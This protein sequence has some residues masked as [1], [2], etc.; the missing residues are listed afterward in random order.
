MSSSTLVTIENQLTLYGYSIF[1]IL[2][3]IGN[4]FILIIFSRQ[5]QTAC[6]IYLISTAIMNS[7]VLTFEGIASIYILYYPERTTLVLMFCKIYTYMLFTLG[8]QA[9]TMLILACIDRFLMTSDRASFR[10][11]STPKRAKY[12]I[13][14]CCIFWSLSNIHIP[15]MTTIVHGQCTRSGVYSI[16]Y[17]VYLLIF[18]GLIPTTTSAIFGYLTYRNMRQI[19]TRV[20]PVVQNTINVNV[21]MQRRD[22][23]LLIIV[24]AEIF[25]YVVTTTLFPLIQLETM[26]SQYV[27]P[28]KSFQYSQIEIFIFNIAGVLLFINNA[29]PFYTYLISSKSFRHDFKQLITNIYGKLGRERPA[30]TITIAQIEHLTQRETRV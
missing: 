13:F 8:Q 3:N 2:G 4:V 21:T 5:R 26:I 22:R 27:L 20:Q 14:F 12:L 1:M 10:A 6:A 11:L 9:K 28:N 24:I 7:V 18:V 17:S 19:L 23:D 29:A 30:Q 16:I 15:I 25:V